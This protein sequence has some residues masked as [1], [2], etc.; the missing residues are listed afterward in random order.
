MLIADDY[1]AY[2]LLIDSSLMIICRHTFSASARCLYI[3]AFSMPFFI[4]DISCCHMPPMLRRAAICM[5]RYLLF[6]RD[7][8]A[9]M[10][11]YADDG[12]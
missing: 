7:N 12:R 9:M 8:D 2:M 1:Y 10:L 11:Y 4:D 5:R 6:E 3:I